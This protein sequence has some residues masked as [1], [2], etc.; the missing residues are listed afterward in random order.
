MVN[1]YVRGPSSLTAMT[2]QEAGDEISRMADRFLGQVVPMILK[3][4]EK[5]NRARNERCLHLLKDWE[6]SARDPKGKLFISSLCLDLA[7]EL[8]GFF[9]KSLKK[10]GEL[11]PEVCKILD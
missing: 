8:K 3:D 4:E 11:Y 1:N 6:K 7:P 2:V 9:P 5:V 10:G